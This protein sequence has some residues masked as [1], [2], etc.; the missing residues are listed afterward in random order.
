MGDPN[1]NIEGMYLLAA[2]D[3]FKICQEEEFDDIRIGVSFY[4]I[5]CGKAFD[6]LNEREMCPIRVDSK[7]RVNIVGL[8][9]KMIPNT[10]SL[11]ALINSGLQERITGVNSMNNKSSWSHAILSI[12]L[13]NIENGKKHGRLSFIDLAGSERGADTKHSTS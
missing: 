7:E 5:Y 11:M 13:R 10:E 1:L 9:E 12:T 3:I 2:K 4:E 8:K 6:L